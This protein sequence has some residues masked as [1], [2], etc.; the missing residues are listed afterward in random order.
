MTLSNFD[1]KILWHVNFGFELNLTLAD[2]NWGLQQSIIR[3]YGRQNLL[4]EILIKSVLFIFLTKLELEFVKFKDSPVDYYFG[5]KIKKYFLLVSQKALLGTGQDCSKNIE[6]I[7]I[8]THLSYSQTS[9][10]IHSKF[11]RNSLSGQLLV[12]IEIYNM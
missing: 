12:L 8:R 3:F 6:L 10:P 7:E 2:R 1:E 11:D 9:F 5:K 4:S